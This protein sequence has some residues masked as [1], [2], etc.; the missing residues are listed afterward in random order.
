VAGV[1]AGA[2]AIAVSELLAGVVPGVPSLVVAVGSLVIALQPPGAK[3]AVATLF[4]TNDKTALNV[5]V[6]VVALLVAAAAGILGR[7][8]FGL[9]AQLLVGFG[10]VA[11]VAAAL[12]PLNSQVLAA[13]NAAIATAASIATLRILLAEAG[14]L[15]PVRVGLPGSNRA[16]FPVATGNA[17]SL[18]VR[19]WSRRRFLIRSGEFLVGALALGAFGRMLLD[20][21]HP[22]GVPV[23][24]NL[25]APAEVTPPLA[26]AES[27]AAPGITPIVVSNDSFY[28]IDTELLV[29]QVDASG[30]QLRVTGMIDHPLTFTYPEL[31][32]M[33]LS[34]ST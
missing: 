11:F 16:A 10:F 15:A 27:L 3:D 6:V 12:Q 2:V 20:R 33:P 19:D 25:P 1:I 24:A 17:T 28:R 21:Q 9:A 8:S 5:A 32:A 7:R 31:V 13:V 30:W 29:P 26:A 14:F 22:A 18:L 34:S 4:G 23:S